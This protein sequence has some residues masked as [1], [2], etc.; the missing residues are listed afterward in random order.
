LVHVDTK[1]RGRCGYHTQRYRNNVY[2]TALSLLV[3]VF[4][5]A[6]VWQQQKHCVCNYFFE[7]FFRFEKKYVVKIFKSTKKVLNLQS[8]K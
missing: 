1:K 7:H 6:D 8:K 3:M 5:R 4:C 2:I